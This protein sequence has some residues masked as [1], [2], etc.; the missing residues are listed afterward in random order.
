[1]E[2]DT[3][4]TTTEACELLGVS[5]TVIKRMADS[6]ELETWKTPGGHRRLK[7]ESVLRMMQE[8]NI[9]VT[10]SKVLSLLVIDDDPTTH[11]V[12]KSFAK[13]NSF[14]CEVATATDGYEGLLQAG[15]GVFDLILVDLNMPN[16]D[17]YGAV[18][19]MKGLENTESSTIM[20]ITAEIPENIKRNKLPEDV[21]VLHKPLQQDVL[22]AF[23]KYE[24]RLK[25]C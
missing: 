21:V 25:S 9:P 20:V 1:M 17:G 13:A 3:F 6:G 5:K 12:I 11:Q 15:Q 23:M 18:S 7:R 16:L 22:R 24:F 8:Q 19:A 4:I 14:K 10:G 2:K